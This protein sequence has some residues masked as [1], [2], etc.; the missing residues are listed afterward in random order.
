MNLKAINSRLVTASLMTAALLLGASNPTFACGPGRYQ[1]QC[2]SG[3]AYGGGIGYGSG[4]SR[5][6]LP[7]YSSSL[8]GSYSLQHQGN[9]YNGFLPSANSNAYR[10]IEQQSVP[11]TPY[12]GGQAPNYQPQNP[13]V[14]PAVPGYSDPQLAPGAPQPGYGGH[15]LPPAPLNRG[16]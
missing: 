14:Y 5:G 7:H 4:N 8:R 13:T 12:Y 9:P 11:S 6:N 10:P 1:G 2:R 15:V 16:Y 3:G